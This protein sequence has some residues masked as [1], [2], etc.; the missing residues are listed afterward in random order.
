MQE[1]SNLAQWSEI[2]RTG[3][4]HDSASLDKLR[5][6]EGCAIHFLIRCQPLA[7]ARPTS[8]CQALPENRIGPLMNADKR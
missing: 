4:P 2:N 5:F 3:Y 8:I 6:V 7:G 1:A